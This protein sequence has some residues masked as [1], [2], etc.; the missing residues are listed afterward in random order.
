MKFMTDAFEVTMQPLK[1]ETL[2]RTP[3]KKPLPILLQK[4][5]TESDLGMLSSLAFTSQKSE[6]IPDYDEDVEENHDLA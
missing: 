1:D 2:D 4:Q 3:R 5:G 6:P